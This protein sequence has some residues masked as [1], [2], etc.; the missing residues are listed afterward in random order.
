VL[1]R[2]ADESLNVRGASLEVLSDLL[3]SI[4]VLA[5]GVVLITT[6]W[7]YVDPIVGVAIGLF[8]LPR[9]YQ[10]GR[11]ALRVL[12]EMAPNDVDLEDARGR[13]V[14]IDGVTEVHDLHVWT[15]TSG[16]RAATAHLLLDAGVEPRDVLERAQTVLREDVGIEHVTFQLEP[17]G[18][19][20]EP[21]FV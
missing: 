9:A 1:R 11:E 3:G 13:L 21:E 8:I 19:K 18:F 7:P 4:S 16:M 14:G 10:L 12:L 17:H 5:A 20:H 6:G 15:L 2:G